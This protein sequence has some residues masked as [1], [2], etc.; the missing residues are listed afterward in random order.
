MAGK[1][2]WAC[3][4]SAT[5]KGIQNLVAKAERPVPEVSGK[6]A[7]PLFH[8]AQEATNNLLFS[9]ASFS[10]KAGFIL[11][12]ACKFASDSMGNCTML[13]FQVTRVTDP[14]CSSASYWLSEAGQG[15]QDAG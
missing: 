13:L 1:H 10:R 7:L 6:C 12:S 14:P 2:C 11:D 4:E 9:T 15:L 5:E 8:Q 3:A